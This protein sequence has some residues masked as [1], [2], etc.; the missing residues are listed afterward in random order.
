M[1]RKQWR[2]RM[3]RRRHGYLRPPRLMTLND[4]TRRE[5]RELKRTLGLK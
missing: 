5:I 3:K 4:I 1:T 2:K